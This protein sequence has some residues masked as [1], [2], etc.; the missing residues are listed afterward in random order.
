MDETPRIPLIKTSGAKNGAATEGVSL[1]AGN[2]AIAAAEIHPIDALQR[3]SHTNGG[4]NHTHNPY[5]DLHFVRSVYGS[6]LA[7]EMAAERQLAQR[8]RGM[9]MTQIGRVYQDV[10]GGTDATLQ[11]ADFMSLPEHRADLPKSVFHVTMERHLQN[12]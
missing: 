6:G 8:E 9:G 7:M 12:L 5:Q 2:L 1:N 10:T 4:M 11:F 3:N